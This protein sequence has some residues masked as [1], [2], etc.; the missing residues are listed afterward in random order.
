MQ[1]ANLDIQKK[2]VGNTYFFI[3]D[4]LY[5]G[6]GVAYRLYY[7]SFLRHLYHNSDI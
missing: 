1:Q 7:V 6:R 2:N 3:I 4:D 5:L